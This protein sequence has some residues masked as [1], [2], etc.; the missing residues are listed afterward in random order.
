MGNLDGV[1]Q[2]ILT[3]G[4]TVLLTAQNL[5][6]L[7]IQVVNTG[8][9]AG[10]LALL[11]DGA[12]HF[13]PGLLHHIL[14]TGGMDPPVGNELLQGQPG[15]LPADGVKAADGDGFGGVVND[16]I[17]AGNGFQGPDVP[18]LPADDP[19]LHLVIGQGHHGNGGLRGMIGGAALNGGGDNL[20]GLFLGLVLELLLDLL[21][22]HGSIVADIL[23]HR[24]KQELLGLL[25]GQAGDLLQSGEL[26]LVGLLGGLLGLG[27]V[28]KPAAQLLLLALKGF[29]LLVQGRFF[30][31]QAALLLGQLRPTVFDFLFEICARFMDFV[32]GLQKHFLLPVFTVADGFVDQTGSLRLRGADFPLRNLLAVSETDGASDN[33]PHGSGQNNNQIVIPFHNSSAHLLP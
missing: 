15:N 14:D 7:R 8:L 11:T 16:E 23:L 3:V 29:G 24:A 4:G 12:V 32:L 17:H 13:L 26:L 6:K 27:R 2:H 5:N 33:D 9:V 22:L 20:P 18:A 21:D 31:L 25:L 30:L 19:S 1:V 10:P 28:G